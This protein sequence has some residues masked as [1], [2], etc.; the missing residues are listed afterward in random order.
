MLDEG[1][2]AD[3]AVMAPERAAVGLPPG[4]AQGIG[5]HAVAH[6]DLEQTRE[7][8]RVGQADD[9]LLEDADLGALL[10]D[11]RQADDRLARHQA[12]GVE[13]EHE[14]EPMPLRAQEVPDIAGL[15]AGIV[16]AA[17]IVQA[18][19][20]DR[21]GRAG[22][23]TG[24]APG[25]PSPVL[26][27]VA[28]DEELEGLRLAGILQA[29]EHGLEMAEDPLGLLLE[30]RDHDRGPRAQGSL[31]VGAT[32][33]RGDV[34]RR[35][36]GQEQDG[37]TD[38]PVPEAEHDPG[39]RDREQGEEHGIDRV[40]AVAAEMVG[41]GQDHGRHRHRDQGREQRTAAAEAR[42]RDRGHARVTT[43]D[44]LGSIP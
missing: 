22:S 4:R 36:A 24:A 19:G 39:Q 11:P 8:R 5:A 20:E 40:Q 44:W 37:Q 18:L 1:G 9:E 26:A 34:G 38:Q 25:L 16:R 15:V 2:D 33:G 23:R 43:M 29:A 31:Q 6:P 35:V 41:H 30:D 21:G 14:V 3:D 12:V 28:Q 7:R 27:R 32:H 17:A 42:V 13:H 10:D